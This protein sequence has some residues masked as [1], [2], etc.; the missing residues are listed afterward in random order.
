M[1]LHQQDCSVASKGDLEMIS[2]ASGQRLITRVQLASERSFTLVEKLL[3]L[4]RHTQ[5][6]SCGKC[7]PSRLQAR[8]RYMHMHSVTALY[9]VGRDCAQVSPL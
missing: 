9:L 5:V 6:I 3:L 1:L 2:K 8:V 7:L 4:K